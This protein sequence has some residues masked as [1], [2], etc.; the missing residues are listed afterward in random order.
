MTQKPSSEKL[1]SALLQSIDPGQIA[2]P[3]VRQTVEVLL[4]LIEQLNL[5]NKQLE[6]EN[7]KLRDEINQ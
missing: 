1:V 2:D 3:H 6:E 4:N 5:K 7:Q